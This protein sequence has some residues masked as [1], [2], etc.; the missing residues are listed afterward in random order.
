MLWAR[1]F[2]QAPMFSGACCGLLGERA[3]AA[4]GREGVPAK[5]FSRRRESLRRGLGASVS[6]LNIMDAESIV[7]ACA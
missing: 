3:G 6:A 7:N 1:Y 4:Q 5:L 2:T